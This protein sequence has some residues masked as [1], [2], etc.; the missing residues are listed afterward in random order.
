VVI[1]WPIISVAIGL[2]Q[3]QGPRPKCAPWLH[4]DSAAEPMTRTICAYTALQKDRLLARLR[5]TPEFSE[6]L[7]AAK[8]CPTRVLEQRDQ[9]RH[10]K[11]PTPGSLSW[12]KPRRSARSCSSSGINLAAAIAAPPEAKA[13]SD[14]D[15]AVAQRWIAAWNSRNPD[16]MLPPVHGR[17]LLRRRGFRRG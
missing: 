11:R 10:G 6:L 1:S 12:S 13:D 7:A 15:A 5:G 14:G 4:N 2:G 9:S 16:K 8:D 17:Y 3:E